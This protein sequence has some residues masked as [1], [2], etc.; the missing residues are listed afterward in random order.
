MFTALTRIGGRRALT[1]SAVALVV[2]AVLLWWLQ[3]LGRTPPSGQISFGT[4]TKAGVY[5]V[6]GEHLKDKLA[7]DMPDLA[8]DLV[9]SRGSGQNVAMVATGQVQFAVAAADAVED[10]KRRDLKGARQLRGVVRLYDDYVHLV[11]PVGSNV[12]RVADLEG[13]RVGTG[14]ENSGVRL[15]AERVLEAAG[16]DPEHDIVPHRH[17]IDEGPDQ[18][19]K[20]RLDA[21]FWSGGI[22]TRGLVDLAEDFDYRFVPIDSRLVADLHRQDHSLDHYRTT[23]L[24]ESAYRKAMNGR[25]VE[26]LAVPN[27]LI[28]RDD[29]DP[30]LTEW[31]T[32]TVIDSRDEIG[33]VVHSAQL[34]DVRTAI[35]THPV[36]L[37]AGALRYYR[38]VKP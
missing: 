12:R 24:P 21:F 8:V 1:G 34:V 17:G 25:P 33:E 16:L 19:R 2:L 31:V 36:S 10:Y 23:T 18:L 28:T 22:P 37:H 30:E 11:V 29:V 14:P 20:G 15:I 3:P 13:L 5:Q 27:L 6:Y 7:V 38:S 26:T 32:R 4:G 9:E 35:D